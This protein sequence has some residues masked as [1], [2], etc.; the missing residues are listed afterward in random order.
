MEVR[1]RSKW[2]F[3]RKSGLWGSECPDCS[4]TPG[5]IVPPHGGTACPGGPAESPHCPVATGSFLPATSGI[6]PSRLIALAAR[7]E[8]FGDRTR[9]CSQF[10]SFSSMQTARRRPAHACATA[11]PCARSHRKDGAGCVTGSGTDREAQGRPAVPG[12]GPSRRSAGPMMHA[13]P[14]SRRAGLRPPP[15]RTTG[16]RRE[17]RETLPVPP[18]WRRR[19]YSGSR[20]GSGHACGTLADVLIRTKRHG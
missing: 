9:P 11:P 3:G 6:V 4:P 16:L 20:E 1:R 15:D 14:D 10:C 7:P 2:S 8:L 19:T 12:S 5:A 13:A 18:Q 17:R